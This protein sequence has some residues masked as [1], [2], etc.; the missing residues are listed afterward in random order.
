LARRD[1]HR[2]TSSRIAHSARC[3]GQ[4][5]S[6]PRG[7]PTIDR[8]R[9]FYG[10][11]VPRRP[12]AHQGRS[13]SS[14]SVLRR[15]ARLGPPWHSPPCS[16]PAR[17]ARSSGGSAGLHGRQRR[18]RRHPCTRR[19]SGLSRIMRTTRT[20]K[21]AR[22]ALCS[23]RTSLVVLRRVRLPSGGEKITHK[24]LSPFLKK[25]AAVRRR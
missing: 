3:Y 15:R 4:A 21:A 9:P 5:E 8:A 6:P 25:N 22:P 11:A 7:R 17:R 16:P 10:H 12:H 23:G 14:A 13:L 19:R 2:S 1:R 24:P 18:S 20:V